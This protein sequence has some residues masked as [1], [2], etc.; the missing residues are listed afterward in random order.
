[1]RYRLH[2]NEGFFGMVREWDPGAGIDENAIR[3][4][5]RG[6]CHAFAWALGRATGWPIYIL[7]QPGAFADAESA[8]QGTEED[9]DEG[10]YWVHAVVR[11]PRGLWLDVTGVVEAPDFG[12]HGHDCLEPLGPIAPGR[13]RRISLSGPEGMAPIRLSKTGNGLAAKEAVRLWTQRHLDI[14]NVTK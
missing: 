12:M 7:S 6:N 8:I 11:H 10:R 2:T 9:F 14:W 3:A 13:L 4:F 1:M 5:T